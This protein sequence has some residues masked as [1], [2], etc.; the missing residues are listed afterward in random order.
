MLQWLKSKLSYPLDVDQ[1]VPAI[2]PAS[3][4]PATHQAH[5]SASTS[6]FPR[7]RY[8]Y[9]NGSKFSGGFGATELLTADYWT[10]RA[11]SSQLFETNHYARGLIRR[12]VTNEINT[13][14]HLE[15]SPVESILGK[16]DDALAEWSEDVETRFELWQKDAW[17][18]DHN[19]QMTLGAI[20]ALVR[21]EAIVS[22]DVL[23]VLRQHKAT[24]LP[25]VQLISGS[26]VRTPLSMTP[27][28]GNRIEHGVEIDSNDRHVA[29]WVTQRDG[30]SKRLPSWGDKSG[31]K[32][33]WLVY[34][35]DKRL[36]A[37]RGKPI[38]SLVLQSLREIDRYR[39]S[40]QR[41]AV[42]NSMLAMF[43]QKA[44]PKSGTQ[45][46][47]GGAVRRGTDTMIDATGTERSFRAADLIP[48]LVLEELQHG[49]TP[50]AFPSH[51]TDEKFGD[52]ETAIIQSIAWANEIP[53]EI[54]MLSFGSNYSASQ[55][56]IN[57]FKIYMNK[58]RTTFGETFCQPIYVEWLVSMA[59][60]GKVSAPGLL[61][62]WRDNSRYDIF[63]AWTCADWSGNIKPAVD[64]SKLV[65]GYDQ[66]VASGYMTRDRATRE[67]SGTKFSTNV[68]KL[69]RE[70]EALAEANEPLVELERPPAPEPPN[71]ETG[72]SVEERLPDEEDER[73]A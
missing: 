65:K 16:E 12:L 59:L 72:D 19:E 30:K 2:G 43:V 39:D 63:A 58:V 44:E 46:I 6:T 34:G 67:L 38:L 64:I 66:M 27:K 62:A 11:R 54:L 70:N 53:P 25:R 56:A 22:G 36:D 52:F 40:T 73:A 33:A 18:C 7:V 26:A 50:H 68:K 71:Q 8:S 41:K 3:C 14:L 5:P 9:D 42:I 57:E 13:G 47:T 28:S 1:V 21:M 10:L 35:T 31:R 32:L 23:V 51:G 48:G 55:A 17:L 45:S 20:Q 60:T 29:Y 15:A 24:G 69:R 49:E 61:E 4:E 37:V